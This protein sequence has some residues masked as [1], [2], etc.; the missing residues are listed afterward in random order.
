M[1]PSDKHSSLMISESLI[2]DIL[3]MY[4]WGTSII[5]KKYSLIEPNVVIHSL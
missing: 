3:M 1:I 4:I 5:R 2:I